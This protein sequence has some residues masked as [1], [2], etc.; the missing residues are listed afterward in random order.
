MLVVLVV[1][2]ET[3]FVFYFYEVLKTLVPLYEPSPDFPTNHPNL[4]SQPTIVYVLF[5]VFWTSSV[6]IFYAQVA[7]QTK[8]DSWTSRKNLQG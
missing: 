2:E 8:A 3:V 4:V 6:L 5:Q 1:S 7:N